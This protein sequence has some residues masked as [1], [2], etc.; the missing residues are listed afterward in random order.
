MK[1]TVS[2]L[3]IEIKRVK[4]ATKS[5]VAA[6]AAAAATAAYDVAGSSK[7]T[8][9]IGQTVFNSSSKERIAK[10]ELQLKE[11]VQQIEMYEKEKTNYIKEIKYLKKEATTATSFVRKKVEELNV[12]IESLHMKLQERKREL[13]EQAAV[14][15][16]QEMKWKEVQRDIGDD[17]KKRRELGKYNFQK[18]EKGKLC[19]IA[20]MKNMKNQKSS[21]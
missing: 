13:D 12:E 8:N 6:A 11:A 14:A 17:T 2:R 5:D 21:C 18:I 9:K 20:Y 3:N 16:E 4:E 7:K 19:A 10:A 1:K 15:K